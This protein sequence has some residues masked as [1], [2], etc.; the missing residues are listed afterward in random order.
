[1]VLGA[2]GQLGQAVTTRLAMDGLQV[3]AFQRRASEVPPEQGVEV[4]LG[5]ARDRDAVE[6]ALENQDAVINTIGSGTLRR[7]TVES[8][9]TAAVLAAVQRRG[10]RRYVGMSAGLVA[11]VSF[12]FDHLIRPLILGNLYREH[13]AVEKLIRATDLDWTIVRPSRLINAPPRGYVEASEKLPRRTMNT[14]R[15]DVAA[16][17]AKE[18]RDGHYVRQAVFVVSE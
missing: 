2:G 11:D 1:V 8:D 5:D 7:N 13:V 4:V 3:R 18:L 9:T 16:F 15:A 17:I 12:V 6:R 14:T 10:P